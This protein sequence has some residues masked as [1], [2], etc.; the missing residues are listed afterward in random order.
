MNQTTIELKSLEFYAHHGLLPEEATLGQRFCIDL[1]LRLT[2]GLLF[3]SDGIA[4]TINYAQVYERVKDL[5]LGQRFNLL[6][7]AAEAIAVDL[8]DHFSLLAEVRIKI[9]KPSVPV[10]CIC[11]Y[12]AVEITRCR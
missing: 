4:S 10:D 2:D 6:E 1:S 5:F 9:R 3:E 12:F 8:L 11:E 7:A